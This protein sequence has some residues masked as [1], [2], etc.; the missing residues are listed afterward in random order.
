MVCNEGVN[1]MKKTFLF[2]CSFYFLVGII[3]ILLGSLSPYIIQEYH[4]DLHDLSFLIFFQFT[5]FL[6]GV[7]LAPIFVRRTSHM[8]VLTF[9]LLLIL[10]T[11]LGV[12]LFDV[13]I[14]FVI[15]GFL[16]G[17]GA[18]TLETTMGAYVIA[19]DK[20]AK[21]MNILEVF[22]GLG[23]LLFPFLIYILTERYAWHFPL[24]ALF[25]FVFVLACMWVVYLRRKTPDTASG[26]MA[27]QEKPTV[28]A[29]FEIGRKEKNIFLFLIFAFVYAGIETNFANFLPA[30]ML[31]KGAEE[32]SVISVTFF[33][34]GMVC[35]R[36]LTSIFGGRLTSVAFLIFSAGALTV[37]L[38]ILAWFPVHQLQLLLV[39]FIGL[40][41]A[42]IFP[43][44]V[45]LASLAGKP[46]TEE[47]TSLFISSASLGGA[48]LSFL[49]GWAI[50][51][52]AAAVFPFLLFGGLGGLLLVISAVI[53]L[54]GLQKNKQ[55]HL[56]M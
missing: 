48:L 20:N 46:F 35:G 41:A 52:S 14:F 10:V 36:L 28:S 34:T 32:I 54:S 12:F 17:F 18:G 9:G 39:F 21:G 33:W 38:L 1:L 43:C 26:Q 8:A 2:G 5:G 15:M 19:Q 45:T 22:F 42:G 27:Y 50:D 31:E 44:A 25:I 13:F 7:L 37:L 11:L 24:Y 53:F 56:E 30:L 40:S 47:I 29:I 51:A 55:S 6:I 16:L 23:A 4:R 49:I 3:H